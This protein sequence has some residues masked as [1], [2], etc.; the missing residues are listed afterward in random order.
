IID[1]HYEHIAFTDG[2]DKYFNVSKAIFNDFKANGY[3]NINQTLDNYFNMFLL[4]GGIAIEQYVNGM[5]LD[6][7]KFDK[8]IGEPLIRKHYERIHKDEKQQDNVA[9]LLKAQ[10][11]QNKMMQEAVEKL[12]E[13]KEQENKKKGFISRLFNR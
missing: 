4:E 5:R 2:D 3:E 13:Q 6:I 10:V 11:E 9:D 7:D 8:L 1:D 12:T